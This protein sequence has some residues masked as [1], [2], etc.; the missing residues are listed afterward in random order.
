MSLRSTSSQT[1]LK[2][3]DAV[4]P[5]RES[6]PSHRIWNLFAVMLGHSHFFSEERDSAKIP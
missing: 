2:H 5:R 1:P 6:N 4:V 3:F